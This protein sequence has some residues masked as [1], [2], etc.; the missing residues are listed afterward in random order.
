MRGLNH[1]TFSVSDLDKSFCFYESILGLRP[2]ARLKHCA[3]FLAGNLWL[4]IV[5]ESDLAK[6]SRDDY[7]HVA[8]DC[9]SEEFAGLKEKLLASGCREWSVN[10]SEGDSFY[11]TDPD[12]HKLEIHIG[13]LQSRLNAIRGN[14]DV[15]IYEP[16]RF[17]Q[18]VAD[19]V[20]AILEF[21]PDK[22]AFIEPSRVLKR[23]EKM[24]EHC[25]VCFFNDVI[26]SLEKQ[27]RLELITQLKSEIGYNPVYL[28]KNLAMPVA[29]L[30]P[31]VGA[32][33]AA[34]FI[35]EA[36]ALGASRFIACGG[37]GSLAASHQVGKLI[38]P[39]FAVRDEGTSYH[40]MSHEIQA[41]PTAAALSAVVATLEGHSVDYE[42][43]GTWT[44]DG[45]YR[46]TRKKIE[47]KRKM[48]CSCVEMEAAALFAVARF[49]NVEMAQILY[50]GDD[51]SGEFW[52]SRNWHSR[53]DI[54][55][56]LLELAIEACL[57][58]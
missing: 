39:T 37:A 3:Y 19:E 34:G 23:L 9:S 6:S 57:K 31:G 24:P 30:H 27:G 10:H 12:G 29:L 40:Y 42:C 16:D 4:A 53:T 18:S 25:V 36:I 35:E 45:I 20:P 8:F 22:P 38:V 50:A 48:G 54:R 14:Q 41:V 46:E 58:I 2:V 44:T 51:L 11:F 56:R 28:I 13:D 1:I 33:L 26:A 55:E 47:D 43:A 5:H 21:D 7:T 52:D 15:H 17:L 49:R 32:P